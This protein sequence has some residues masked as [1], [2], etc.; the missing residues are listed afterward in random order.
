MLDIAT[1]QYKAIVFDCDGVLLNSNKIK[2]YL[3]MKLK[4]YNF[5]T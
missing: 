2:Q 4:S 3:A 1:N 5:V